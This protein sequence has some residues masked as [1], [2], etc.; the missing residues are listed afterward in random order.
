MAIHLAN[1]DFEFELA[2]PEQGSFEEVWQK[3]PLCLQLQFLP[4]LYA[5]AD[6]AIAVIAPPPASFT[7]KILHLGLWKSEQELPR[8]E[9]LNSKNLERYKSCQ[10]WGYSQN[11]QKWA[12][13]RGLRYDMPDWDTV[14]EVNSK[15]FTYDYAPRLEGA[16][17]I[18]NLED[19][20]LWLT[21]VPGPKVLK[22]CFGLSGRGNRLIENNTLSPSVLSLCQKEWQ[23]GRPVIGEPWLNRIL[24]F[25]TQW[26]I[27]QQG[28]IELVGATR[29][30]T[31]SQGSY[32][33][34]LAGPSAQLFG[35]MHPFLDQHCHFA[36][37]LLEYAASKKFWGYVGLDALLYRNSQEQVELYPIVELNGR[38]T[39]S[40]AAL[41]FQK[42]WFPDQVIALR[43]LPNQSAISLLPMQWNALGKSFE[44]KRSL[45][46][47]KMNV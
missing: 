37:P 34:T 6:E 16:A 40:L 26:F 9:C 5:E 23:Q 27:S 2:T 38:R 19:L 29:F 25:S 39:M 35:T 30:E 28:D 36:Y 21:T 46:F 18:K 1:T 22:T 42:K 4:L 7:E 3:Y 33:G 45:S 47:A 8:W 32:Q 20:T 41:C 11:V 44:F 24:D 15:A 17:S 12:K 13:D 10:S 43:F 31:D 14:K